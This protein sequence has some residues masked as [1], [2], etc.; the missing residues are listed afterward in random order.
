MASTS[1]RPTSTSMTTWTWE[2]L[3]AK[4]R[5]AQKHQLRLV[6]MDG[7]FFMDGDIAPLRDICQL[8]QKYKAMVFIDE[9]YATGFLGPTGQG[10]DELLRVMDQVTIIN[11]TLGKALGGWFRGL[12]NRALGSHFS[13]P[14]AGLA[15]P[16]LQQPPLTI[17]GCVSKALDLLMESN[18]ITGSFCPAL[19]CVPNQVPGN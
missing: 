11:S 15:L 12:H 6:D 8:A 19:Y 1:V 14:A 3:E 10:T 9:G 17:V 7:A 5:D 18:A 2:D 16:L 4:L 13:S